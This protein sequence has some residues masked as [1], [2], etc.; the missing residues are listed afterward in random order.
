MMRISRPEDTIH[1]GECVV[2][3]Y[4]IPGMCD[5]RNQ[6]LRGNP[7]LQQLYSARTYGMIETIE[8]VNL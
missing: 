2:L 3:Q 8:S 7:P 6:V 1:P 4:S 5:I